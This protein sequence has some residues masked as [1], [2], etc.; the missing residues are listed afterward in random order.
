MYVRMLITSL[1]AYA[2]IYGIVYIESLKSGEALGFSKTLPYVIF[3]A[4]Q[5]A[6]FIIGKSHAGKTLNVFAL[7]VIAL[8]LVTTFSS[9]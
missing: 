1:A 8:L 2:L 5:Y 6:G 3:L 4:V 7:I 9:G